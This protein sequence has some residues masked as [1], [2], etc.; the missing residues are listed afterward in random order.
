M[1][2]LDRILY[3]PSGGQF[4]E[5]AGVTTHFAPS[6]LSLYRDILPQPLNM[7]SR[8]TVT[9]FVADYMKVASWPLTPYQEW[10]VL[11]RCRYKDHEGWYPITMP[12]TAWVPMKGGRRIGFPKYVVD[13]IALIKKGDTITA[14]AVHNGILQ[15]EL[16]FSSGHSRQLSDWEKELADM[17]AFFKGGNLCLVPP[18]VGPQVMKVDLIHV[19]SPKWIPQHGMV[20]VHANPGESWTALLAENVPFPGTYNH[21]IG[22]INLQVERLD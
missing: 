8:P 4:K 15:L 9:I 5:F 17:E 19:V 10:S 16:R 22:G 2:L 11:L 12:V 20:T 14:T 3:E 13:N 7:P 18:E 21:F 1:N 6:D